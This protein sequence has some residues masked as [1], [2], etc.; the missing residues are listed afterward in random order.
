MTQ[1]HF[2]SSEMQSDSMNLML[3]KY[4]ALTFSRALGAKTQ[5]A[6]TTKGYWQRRAC[7]CERQKCA[8]K[9]TCPVA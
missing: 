5:I 9:R 6:M 7:E 1:H 3:H 4:S 2:V 8:T